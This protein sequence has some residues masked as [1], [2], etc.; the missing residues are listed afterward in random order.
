MLCL[1]Y[2]IRTAPSQLPLAI[3]SIPQKNANPPASQTIPTYACQQCQDSQ[4]LAD[5]QHACRDG[6]PVHGNLAL[7]P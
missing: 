6:G 2:P 3:P 1:P 4:K 7:A 5:G